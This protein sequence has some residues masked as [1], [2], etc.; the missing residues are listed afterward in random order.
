MSCGF[1]KK[2]EPHYEIINAVLKTHKQEHSLNDRSK[3]KRNRINPF[4]TKLSTQSDSFS[5]YD[6]LLHMNSKIRFKHCFSATPGKQN[7]KAKLHKSYYEKQFEKVGTKLNFDKINEDYIPYKTELEKQENIDGY[8][9]YLTNDSLEFTKKYIEAKKRYYLH[10]ENGRFELSYPIISYNKKEAVILI[11]TTAIGGWELWYFEKK[12][13]AW[14]KVCAVE[15]G[16]I[17]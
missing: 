14:K 2:A 12:Q 11:S 5:S 17:D 3:I 16:V 8:N 9:F 7:Y 6:I 1:E 4:F 13:D 15:V 10:K